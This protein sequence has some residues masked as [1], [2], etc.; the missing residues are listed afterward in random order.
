[1]L[2]F[3]CTIF[4]QPS[5]SRPFPQL[6]P[7]H[8]LFGNT[9]CAPGGTAIS[10][11]TITRP[12]SRICSRL[13]RPSMNGTSFSSLSIKFFDSFFLHF[14]TSFPI[15]FD[16]LFVSFLFFFFQHYLLFTISSF[17][18]GRL[19]NSPCKGWGDKGSAP[20]FLRFVVFRFVGV[21]FGMRQQKIDRGKNGEW[22][23]LEEGDGGENDVQRYQKRGR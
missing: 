22:E 21:V 7:P 8:T 17:V 12:S 10:P 19:L 11:A 18:G 3:Y 5:T 16:F 6:H 15:Y 13:I 14:I 23:I 2:R 9:T 1:M 4:S 20:L